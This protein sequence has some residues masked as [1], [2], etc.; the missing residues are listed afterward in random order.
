LIVVDAVIPTAELLIWTNNGNTDDSTKLSVSQ[1]FYGPT[2]PT[3]KESTSDDDDRRKLIF[4]P[5]NNPFLCRDADDVVIK[6]E[7]LES[8]KGALMIV[9]RG[10]CTYEHKTWVAQTLYEASGV[11]VY[12]T[13]ASR[14]TFNE[15]DGTT[16][17]WPREYHDYDCDKAMA[18]IPSNELQFFSNVDEVKTKTGGSSPY[19]WEKN[20][21]LLTGDTVD[22]LCKTH[23]ENKLQNCPSKR[24]LVAH[25]SSD[26]EKTT[27]TTADITTVCCAWDLRLNPSPDANIDK[28]ITI[29][30]PTI[31]ATMEQGDILLK[32]M[33][34]SQLSNDG[35]VTV[36]VHSFWRPAYNLSAVLIVFW[37]VMVAGFAAFRSADDYHVGISKL[38]RRKKKDSTYNINSNPA[39][40]VSDGNEED[41]QQQESLVTRSN[42]LADESLE[43]EPIHALVFVIM[44]S[45][46]LF[47]LFF[48][49]IYNV[50]K[51]MY[52]FGCANSFIQ[53]LVYPLLSR[54][55]SSRLCRLNSSGKNVLGERLLYHSDDFGDFTNWDALAG[56]IGYSTGMVWLYMSLCIPQAGDHYTFYW[57][58]QDVLGLCMCVTFLGLIQL[59][60]IRVASA[61]LIVAFF[62]DIFFVFVTPY[63]FKGRSVMIEV[64][65]S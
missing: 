12:N 29:T 14:Y 24:C 57:V 36:S 22:N 46:S 65:V 42:S 21:Q 41:N 19:N 34:K 52:A 60:S 7:I 16:I 38:W 8:T 26:D 13:L 31:F 51:V 20:D 2:A 25:K 62:Y 44:S 63:L 40:A 11:V 53:I 54:F 58:A 15:T 47:I 55:L 17:I 49:K 23:D 27:T 4:P 61:L 59:N 18:E 10:G 35:L 9:P 1:A 39:S 30:I 32:A 56:V 37:G 50:A 48:F 3:Q 33:A 45:I 64:A 28:N 5:A 6:Q 43:L